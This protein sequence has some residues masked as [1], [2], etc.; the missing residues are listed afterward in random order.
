MDL[1]F[2]TD[3][4][5]LFHVLSTGDSCKVMVYLEQ[6][7]YPDPR[8]NNAGGFYWTK[9]DSVNYTSDGVKIWSPTQS[10]IQFGRLYFGAYAGN[11]QY[12]YITPIIS[13]RRF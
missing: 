5:V 7:H 2:W 3:L 8:K 9:I 10:A 1:G 13:R 4:S 11:G 12:T 6:G